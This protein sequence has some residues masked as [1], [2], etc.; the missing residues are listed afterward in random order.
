MLRKKT[1]NTYCELRRTS[2][3][4]RFTSPFST[5]CPAF[6][7]PF[8]TCVDLRGAS[9][10]WPRAYLR[11]S[12]RGAGEFVPSWLHILGACLRLCCLVVNLDEAVRQSGKNNSVLCYVLLPLSWNAYFCTAYRSLLSP[13][14]PGVF[15]RLLPNRYLRTYW[16]LRNYD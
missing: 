16:P 9:V 8:G 3:T 11:T 10:S 14:P 13:N 2:C 7:C 15:F 6:L 4:P 1:N 12:L 5:F